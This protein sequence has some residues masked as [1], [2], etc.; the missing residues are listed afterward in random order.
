MNSRTLQYVPLSLDHR[1]IYVVV[2][3]GFHWPISHIETRTYVLPVAC[4]I[5]NIIVG[6]ESFRRV[7]IEV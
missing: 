6:A 4:V 1:I 7:L 5:E 2:K 3:G